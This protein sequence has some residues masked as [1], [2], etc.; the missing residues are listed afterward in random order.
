MHR[1]AVLKTV[2]PP[3]VLGH[4][5]AD[6]AGNLGRRI[7]GVVEA[8]YSDRLADGQIANTWLNPGGTCQ[9]IN[10]ENLVKPRHA[11]QHA[12]RMR[13]CTA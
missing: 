4:V 9:G 3:C 6:R 10:G 8:V 12:L 11:Q 1:E 5:T 2:H 13:R 7:R